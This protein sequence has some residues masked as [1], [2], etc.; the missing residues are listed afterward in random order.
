MRE[1]EWRAFYSDSTVLKQSDSK[2]S[3]I[4]RSKLVRFALFEDSTEIFSL[5]LDSSKVFFYRRRTK[6]N[7]LNTSKKFFFV[8]GY[9]TADSLMIYLVKPN[10]SYEVLTEWDESDIDKNSISFIG[11]EAV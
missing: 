3:D 4:D 10:G 9:R 11:V 8:I 1:I 2:Y 5:D 6:Q 7:V